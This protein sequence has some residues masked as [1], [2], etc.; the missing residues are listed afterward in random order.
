MEAIKKNIPQLLIGL[1]VIITAYVLGN[2]I[3]NRNRHEDAIAVTGK[4]EKTFTS[5]LIVWRGQYSRYA[6][7]L[8]EAYDMLNADSKLL[9]DYLS[10]KSMKKEDLVFSAVEIEKVYRT[11]TDKDGNSTSF[12]NGYNLS[13]EVKIESKEV[14]KVEALSREVTELIN[15]GLEL[16]SMR[17]EYYYTQLAA[18][19]IEMIAEAT[20]DATLRAQKIAEESGCSLGVLKNGDMGVF[21]IVAPNSSEDEYSWGGSFN[22]SSKEKSASITMSLRFSVE[23]YVF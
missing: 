13:Q 9:N 14:N 18:L 12:F 20:K 10:S 15:K 17:P 5:D 3:Q 21:Q 4:A 2:A 22:T 6:P 8:K 7:T 19:K 23:D 1:S 16:N 11:E